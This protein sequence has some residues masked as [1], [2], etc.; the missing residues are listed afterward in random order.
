MTK[1]ECKI[2][3]KALIELEKSINNSFDK[4]I[5]HINENIKVQ[6]DV[7]QDKNTR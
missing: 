1:K 2:I 6:E 3:V 5:K 4:A 7:K